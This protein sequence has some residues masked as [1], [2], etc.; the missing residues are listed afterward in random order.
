VVVVEEEVGD[1]TTV[2]GRV[3]RSEVRRGEVAER[4]H[5]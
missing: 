5:Y 4:G 2:G 3:R 1:T